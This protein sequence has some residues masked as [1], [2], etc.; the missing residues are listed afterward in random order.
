VEVDLLVFFIIFLLIILGYLE[1]VTNWQC[2]SFVH[3]SKI[4]KTKSKDCFDAYNNTVYNDEK[5]FCTAS[6]TY[7]LCLADIYNDP[8]VDVCDFREV[9]L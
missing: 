4:Y 6:E 5:A 9:R 8:T 2:I 3:N 1:V 7:S